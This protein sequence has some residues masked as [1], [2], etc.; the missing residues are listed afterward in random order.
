MFQLFVRH[1]VLAICNLQDFVR[2]QANNR[3]AIKL[4]LSEE[5][6]C[7]ESRLSHQQKECSMESL[8]ARVLKDKL[9]Q[10]MSL[11]L[12]LDIFWAYVSYYHAFLVNGPQF[13]V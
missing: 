5:R 6:W 10:A 13:T 12:R 9:Q 3:H 7:Q 8:V 4:A 11:E 1:T 2:M